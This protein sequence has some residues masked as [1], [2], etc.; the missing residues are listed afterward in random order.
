M[1]KLNYLIVTRP[2]IVFVMSVVSQ[3]LLAQRI[4]YWYAVIQIL[5]YLKKAPGGELLFSNYEHTK[6]ANFSDADWT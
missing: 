5:R 3:F 4:T 1:Y 2:D 6:V